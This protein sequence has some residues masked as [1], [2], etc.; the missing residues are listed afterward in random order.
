MA[1][2]P[3]TLKVRQRVYVSHFLLLDYCLLRKPPC[4][5]SALRLRSPAAAAAAKGLPA[6]TK[7]LHRRCAVGSPRGQLIS[8]KESAAGELF[9]A[10]GMKWDEL[11]QDPRFTSDPIM[12]NKPGASV[13]DAQLAKAGEGRE[14]GR[15]GAAWRK[16]GRREQEPEGMCAGSKGGG[17]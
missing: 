16:R 1:L 6:T 14:R 13:R 12:T 3:E 17:V 15:A 8:R 2:S 4:S 7:P 10:L 11:H 9:T 5:H